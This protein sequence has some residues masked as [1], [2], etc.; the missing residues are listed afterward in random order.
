MDFKGYNKCDI[1]AKVAS[2]EYDPYRTARIAL[3]HYADG[4]KRYVLGWKGVAVGDQVSNGEKAPIVPGN[5]KQLKHI[6]E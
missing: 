1:P 3:L 5:R 4:E 2:I 6:P